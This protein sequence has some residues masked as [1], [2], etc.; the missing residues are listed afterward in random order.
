MAHID[1]SYAQLRKK[2]KN[3]FGFSNYYAADAYIAKVFEGLEL[4]VSKPKRQK[5]DRDF[6][7]DALYG[8]GMV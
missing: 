2:V 4:D 6:I 8:G 3:Y 5:R 7:H 1:S